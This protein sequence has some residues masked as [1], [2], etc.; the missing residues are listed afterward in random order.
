MGLL[1]GPLLD[2]RRLRSRV[3]RGIAFACSLAV[4]AGTA[5][6][7]STPANAAENPNPARITDASWWLMQELLALDPGT[8]NGGIYN[9]KKGYHNTRAANDPS[10]YSVKDAEDQGGPS[11]KAAAYDWTFPEAQGSA[12]G[13]TGAGQ[14]SPSLAAGDQAAIADYRNIAR[15][16]S[17]LLASGRDPADPRLDGWRE[18]YGQTDNDL[19]VEGWDFRYDYAVSS[20]DSHLWHIHL[21]EDRNKVT[22]LDNKKALLSVLRGETVEEWMKKP[23][24]EEG[25]AR[26]RADVTGDGLDDLVVLYDYGSSTSKLWVFRSIVDSTGKGHRYEDPV[27]WWGSTPG[28]WAWSSSKLVVGNFAKDADGVERADVGILYDYGGANT[29]LLVFRSTGKKFDAP[30]AWWSFNP[31]N[32]SWSSS[33]LVV[34]KFNDDDLDDVGILYDYGD[35]T[36]TLWV[37]RSTGGAFT[38]PDPW[39]E[40]NPGNWSW[41]NSKLV[42]GNFNDDK[43]T[44]VAIMYDYGGA[45]TTLWVLRSIGNDFTAPDPWWEFNPGNWSWSN[46]KLVAGNFNDDKLTDVAIMYDYGGATTTLWVLRSIGNDFTAPDPW[47]EF[48]PGNWSWSNSKLVAGNFNDDKLTDVAIMYDY[49]GATTTLWTLRSI[50][51]DFTAPDPWWESDP[52]N[53]AWSNSKL[54]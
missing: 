14:F 11:D 54:S 47:W 7:I 45:T 3:S 29:G 33:K 44:D 5:V 13:Y 30:V 51:N 8:R 52:G 34:G 21:S 25:P 17:R 50:G 46:S 9:N 49:G 10:N 31:G 40:F 23:G 15:Y 18:F 24:D 19:A 35:A 1:N 43:L 4:F 28:N 53:W 41:S 12:S 26:A 20:D 22:S 27:E 38:A 48:N 2:G 39:W 32:W 36:T 42:A 16:S 37:L 6:L